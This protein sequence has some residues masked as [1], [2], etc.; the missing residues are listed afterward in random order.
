MKTA[1]RLRKCL[2]C[3]M[4]FLPDRRNAQRQCFCSQPACRQAS[5]R[6]SQRQWLARPENQN[7]F[8]DDQNAK[9]VR[10]W[11]KAHPG[12]WKHTTRYQHRTLQEV[13]P[14]Q[15]PVAPELAENPAQRTLQELCSMQVPLLV[16]IISMLADC[17][18]P[19]D[20][21]SSTQRLVIKGHHILGIGLGMHNP[22]FLYEKTCSPSGTPPESASSVQLDRSSAGPG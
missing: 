7:Y 12:Y 19:E 4:F 17:T 9:R 3:Q 21:A 6:Q 20:I 13:C 5:K 11:Q 15:L 2:H 16:G 14:T 10:Q 1:P 22:R 8:R 18:L